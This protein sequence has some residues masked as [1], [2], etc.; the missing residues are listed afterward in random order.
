MP[1]SIIEK[2]YKNTLTRLNN[3]LLLVAILLLAGCGV[4]KGIKK[5]EVPSWH[6][7]LVQSARA[8]VITDDDKLTA[9]ITM[10]T[11][12]DSML[13]ISVMPM[14]GLEVMR[15]E[16]TPTELT[17]IDKLHGQYARA[18]YADLNRKLTPS[19]N[20]DILQQLCAA[21]LPTGNEKA[22]LMYSFGDKTLEVIIDYP[23]R[24]TDVPVKV[25]SQPLKKYKEIDISQWL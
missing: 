4:K 15:L 22:R 9:N 2:K 13:V 7:C 24:K 14:L 5:S 3:I 8:T 17:A 23:P 16:A 25:M 19:I 21:E 1:Q 6:T 18:N 10:Q 20:W 12:R 11:V